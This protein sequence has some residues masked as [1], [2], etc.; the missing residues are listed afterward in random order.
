M[1]WVVKLQRHGG[2]YRITIPRGLI[3]KVGFECAEI[4]ILNAVVKGRIVIEEY[5]GKGKEKRD[6]PED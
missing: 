1:G 5:Y 4:V 6:L 2:Q 3:E